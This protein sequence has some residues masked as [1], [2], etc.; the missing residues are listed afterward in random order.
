M[1]IMQKP[2]EDVL[3]NT[4]SKQMCDNEVRADKIY[5]L[6][7]QIRENQNIKQ[8]EIVHNTGLSK[9]MVSKIEHHNGNPTLATLIKYCSCIN[10]DLEKAILEYYETHIK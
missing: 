1:S 9:Q 3:N 8:S 5:T 2:E 7:K 4:S 6:L 10:I